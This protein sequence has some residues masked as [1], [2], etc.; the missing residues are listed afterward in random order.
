MSGGCRMSLTTGSGH[1]Q[2]PDYGLSCSLRLQRPGRRRQP[3]GRWPGP[4]SR[5][6]C[7]PASAPPAAAAPWSGWAA[8]RRRPCNEHVHR[9][10]RTG[11]SPK[12]KAAFT[13]FEDVNSEGKTTEWHKR[14]A[15]VRPALSLLKARLKTLIALLPYCLSLPMGRLRGFL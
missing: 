9:E 7:P 15:E 10:F 1:L 2:W 13:G 12:G 8:C 14:E 6:G 11:F 5:Q 3:A 4:A